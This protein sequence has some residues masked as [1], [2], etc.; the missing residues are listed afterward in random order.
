MVYLLL[1]Y[2]RVFWQHLRKHE[3][4]RIVFSTLVVILAG[5][6]GLYWLEHGV[7]EGIDTYFD[8]LWWII[9]TMT[10]VGYGDIYPV[11]PWGRLV[12]GFVMLAG[13]GLLTVVIGVFASVIQ[14]INL[15]K[16]MGRLMTSFKEHIIICGW[17]EK[18]E[19]IIA[20]LHGDKVAGENPVVLIA[21]LPNNPLE[22]DPLV[23][24][25]RGRIDREEALTRARVERARSVIVLNEDGE[26]ATSVLACLTVRKLNPATYIVAEVHQSENRCHFEAAGVNEVIVDTEINSRLLLR[27]ALH[28]GI[29]QLVE[30]LTT[31]AY[32]NEIYKMSIQEKWV[33]K[34]FRELYLQFYDRYNAILL[35]VLRD[36]KML[37]NPDG[38]LE[39]LREDG[40]VYVAQEQILGSV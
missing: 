17:S 23:H 24:F 6:G 14:S 27:A 15:R 8:A 34:T 26:D 40:L 13:I 21:D 28:S 10:T 12:A 18:A 11:T 1:E 5:S 31:V 9:V 38:K 19:Q 29:F 30:E 33:G 16:E 4:K 22:E 7:N 3:I 25:V 2:F 32:G 35:G 36:G 20:E 39:L 37:T